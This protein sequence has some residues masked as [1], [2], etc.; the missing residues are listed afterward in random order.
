[1]REVQAA[2]HPAL[3]QALTYAA[4]RPLAKAFGYERRNVAA[5]MS[6]LNASAFALWGLRRNEAGS[7]LEAWTW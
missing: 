3:E 5:D 6:P 7:D 1:M 4:Q 2:A